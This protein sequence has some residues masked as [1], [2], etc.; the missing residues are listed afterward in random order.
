MDCTDHFIWL[1]NSASLV[2]TL[3]TNYIRSY[4][5]KNMNFTLLGKTTGLVIVYAVV[6]TGCST[7][8][9]IDT[10][11]VNTTTE[12]VNS[13]NSNTATVENSITN[14]NSINQPLNKSQNQQNI[15]SEASVTVSAV[16]TTYDVASSNPVTDITE[17]SDEADML[18]AGIDFNNAGDG[19][20]F[21]HPGGI[22]TDGAHLV[23]ADK[24]NNRIL[25]WNSLPDG[26]TA[27]DLVLGQ[28][29]MISNNPGTEMTQLNWPT[30][31]TISGDILAVADTNNDRI[32]IWNSLPTSNGQPADLVLKGDNTAGINQP[33]N[34]IWPWGVWT[35][36]QKFV[37][38]STKGGQLLI[39]DSVP[40]TNN[41][42]PNIII[43]LDD[44]GTPRNIMSDGNSLVVGDHN[45]FDNKHGTFFWST[46]PTSDNEM[47][48][49]F[50]SAPPADTNNP[51]GSNFMGEEMT[52]GAY[53][54]DGKFMTVTNSG[55]S[56]WNQFPT[57]EN[58]TA[59][60]TLRNTTFDWQ[61]GDGAGIALTNEKMY[62][63]RP[64]GNS[65][66]GYRS[67]PTSDREPDFSV[68][69]DDVLTNTLDSHYFITNP[70]P[71]TN[72]TNVF[73]SSD[74]D[75]KVY[76]WKNIPNQTGVYPDYVYD[77]VAGWDNA[78]YN[79][80]FIV[81][82]GQNIYIWDELPLGEAM[83]RMVSKKIGSI[84]VAD[85][86]G[87][88]LDDKYFYLADSTANAIYVW[89]GIPEDNEEPAYILDVE[90]PLRLN[91]DGKYLAV[92]T[93][94]RGS[95][96]QLFDTADLS[97]Q[98][99]IIG[100]ASEYNLPMNALVTDNHLFIADTG[101]NRVVMWKDVADAI[102]GK[103]ADTILGNNTDQSIPEI[104]TD[105]LFM[106]SALAF[107][108]S[109]LWVGEFKFSGRL[110]RFSK[111]SE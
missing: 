108:G 19:Q 105:T 16:G 109:Y 36:G 12:L 40:T 95:F 86:K 45:A 2:Y 74:F 22:A 3:D 17:L 84:E 53:T 4:R 59:D 54:S 79:N 18:L 48:D 35:N 91:S 50:M 89:E 13:S 52:G 93:G 69:S 34:I 92:S 68:G 96:I 88:A 14:T 51:N 81:V 47:Y 58:D 23:L 46:F 21:N 25:I 5:A 62:I 106:P 56:I 97:K 73:V 65:I 104:G 100:D 77:N 72:G 78:L 70:V 29:D 61:T 1:L 55:V 20:F 8:Q 60:V 28:P 9:T 26:N 49:F 85:L 41:Q 64:N 32:L 75:H 71:A 107:D 103:P 37:V 24:N 43:A 39:W 15:F 57:D 90:A 66:V 10:Q 6:I 111:E 83:P 44:I 33:G 87:V 42:K 30:A 67:V 63:S 27:P 102:A 80:T 11:P 38:S 82:G 110:L 98:P 31:V 99:S 101:F 7:T 94:M 76:V